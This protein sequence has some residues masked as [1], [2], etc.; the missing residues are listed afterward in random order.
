MTDERSKDATK[1][2]HHRVSV[3]LLCV[4]VRISTRADPKVALALS[5]HFLHFLRT[6]HAQDMRRTVFSL[7]AMS[8]VLR[9]AVTSRL[10]PALSATTR[11]EFDL[12]ELPEELICLVIEHVDQL[13]S[14]ER[15][16]RTCHQLQRLAE[17][18]LYRHRTLRSGY[19]G[20][21]LLYAL[22]MQTARESY[23]HRLAYLMNSEFDQSFEIMQDL[24][25]RSTH[26]KDFSF[27]SP[28][29][30]TSDFEDEDDWMEM[31][32]HLFRPFQ[33][34]TALQDPSLQLNTKPL[35]MLSKR[36]TSTLEASR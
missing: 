31:T 10:S 6:N 33:D 26:L 7:R 24:L 15:L 28:E 2:E 9:S 36:K 1:I 13:K 16:S 17:P 20:E 12:L 21:E 29:C 4:A 22:D 25:A 11:F 8:R 5:L 18:K 27:E 19:D 35:Q 14:L 30:N 3:P 34:A 32:N 23:I